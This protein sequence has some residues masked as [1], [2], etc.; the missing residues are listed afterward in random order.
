MKINGEYRFETNPESLWALIM[1]REV[2]ERITPGIKTLEET[3]TDSYK[4]ISEVKV[5]PVR[6]E[7][8]GNLSLRN[9]VENESCLVVIDQKS[10]MG[11]V[12]AEIDMHLIGEDGKTRIE[13]TGDA[14]M[15]GMLATMGQRIMSGVISSLSKQFFQALEEEV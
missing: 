14:K 5:G 12:V 3:D 11:N 1:D 13:Y 6:G 7:F 2:L 9:K 15:S 10:K 4:A 8:K